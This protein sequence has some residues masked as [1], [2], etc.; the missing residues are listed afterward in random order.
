MCY[1]V[2]ARGCAHSGQESER[3]KVPIEIDG[4]R[5]MVNE[6]PN[7]THFRF[8]SSIILSNRGMVFVRMLKWFVC[9]LIV[10]LALLFAG[11]DDALFTKRTDSQLLLLLLLLLQLWLYTLCASLFL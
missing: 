8:F 3:K 5:C 1:C 9:A 11:N 4:M 7:K 6:E 10:L 2:S